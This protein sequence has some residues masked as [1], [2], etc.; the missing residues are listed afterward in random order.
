MKRNIL[1]CLLNVTNLVI[2]TLDLTNVIITCTFFWKIF[3]TC[4]NTSN[5]EFDLKHKEIENCWTTAGFTNV[6]GTTVYRLGSDSF[7]IWS[8][9][10]RCFTLHG[11][12]CVSKREPT[13]L[14]HQTTNSTTF[15]LL[16]MGRGKGL[17]IR[18]RWPQPKWRIRVD[19]TVFGPS[20][21]SL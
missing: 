21:E 5:L 9:G 20:H 16:I 6:K 2:Y 8:S 1:L 18:A 13:T 15:R 3:S 4:C 19:F 17:L 10:A 14:M 11:E 7:L 12:A